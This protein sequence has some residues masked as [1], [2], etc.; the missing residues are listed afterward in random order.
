MEQLVDSDQSSNPFSHFKVGLACFKINLSPHWFSV[1][2]ALFPY[3]HPK[4]F[5]HMHGLPLWLA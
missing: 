2:I 3:C 4:G 5:Y 1:F